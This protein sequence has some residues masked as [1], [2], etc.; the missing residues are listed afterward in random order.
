VN[1]IPGA[2]PLAS[3]VTPVYNGAPYLAECIESVLNQTYSNWEYLIGDNASTDATLAIARSYAEQDARI[4]ILHWDD[5]ADVVA[6][7]N[8]LLA[9]ISRDSA[10][11]KF[12]LA[13]DW[14]YPRCL[15]RMIELCQSNPSV[16]MV[17][18]YR[19]NGGAVDLVGI[20]PEDVTVIDGRTIARE[21]LLGGPYLF[22][23]ESNVLYRA[24]LVRARDPE[25]FAELGGTEGE[26]FINFHSDSDV[27]YA[28]LERHDFGFVHET[29]SCTRRHSDSIT[30]LS[31]MPLSSWTPGHLLSV[32]RHGPTFLTRKEFVRRAHVM[33]HRYERL[34]LRSALRMRL[35]R[36][37]RF[38]AYHRG[39]IKRIR[40]VARTTGVRSAGLAVFAFLL[41]L[42]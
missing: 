22:G 41:D 35:L 15:E 28:L 40:V 18:G 30:S 1:H 39:A 10:Y 27:C 4:R 5:Y 13:D 38:R 6:N 11:C 24:D 9:Q 42:W 21:T 7:F 19:L 17:G 37:R 36:D 2:P 16:G 8:R 31:A 34:L 23:T 26:G 32:L 20:V 14:L 29:L 12:V 33:A 25:F 3:V